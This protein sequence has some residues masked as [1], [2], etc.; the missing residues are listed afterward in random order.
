MALINP[1]HGLIVPFFCLFTI[2]LAVFASLTTAL[3]FSVLMFRVAVVYFDMALA[4]VPQYVMGRSR[5]QMLSPNNIHKDSQHGPR[6][7]I[8]PP[9]SVSSG[10]GHSTPN[11]YHGGGSGQLGVDYKSPGRRRKSSY[12]FGSAL[13]HS[14]HSSQ[15]SMASIGTITPI[16]EGEITPFNEPGP[17]P[18]SS[19]FGETG[20]A[21]SVGIDRDFEGIGG[22]RLDE[23]DDSDW[24]NI[25]S[26][27]ELPTER[28]S[29][30]H[31][32]RR[33]QSAG[34]TTPGEAA[35]W[36]MM[37]SPG[38]QASRMPEDRDWERNASK[39]T[40]PSPNGARSKF[41]QNIPLPSA[42]TAL[43]Q[44]EYFPMVSPRT[45]KK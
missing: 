40:T 22:W 44:E 16:R 34:P 42:L 25:N 31:Q 1:V 2:P 6:T 28:A 3:A 33:S 27:L 26:R 30:V 36:M 20:L 21:P 10:S 18:G 12:G 4:L 45:V 7:P 19:S 38:H 13:R 32:H 23:H 41:G 9:S 5:T 39:K 11:H 14:R 37:K 8:S 43:S 35:T 24:A 17:A 15:A 29:F